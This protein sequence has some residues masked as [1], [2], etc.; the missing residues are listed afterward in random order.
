[1][2][3]VLFWLLVIGALVAAV[4]L[5]KTRNGKVVA[6]LIVV[7]LFVAFP[8]RW[9]WEAKQQRD[10][11]R[12]RHEKAEAMFQER[13]KKAGE[14]IYRTAENVEGVFLLRLADR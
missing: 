7:G 3:G 10:A 13:C 6:V 5:P 11:A 1:M 4:R 14:F 8:G 2:V 9:A 12:A